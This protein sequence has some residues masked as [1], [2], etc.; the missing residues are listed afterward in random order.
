MFNFVILLIVFFFFVFLLALG[1]S[2]HNFPDESG[3]D[4]TIP[5]C[6]PTRWRAS[7]P[8]SGRSGS[9]CHPTSPGRMCS[10]GPSPGSI[11]SFR[12]SGTPFLPLFSSFFFGHL[13]WGRFCFYQSMP[14]L[15]GNFPGIV[16]VLA[17]FTVPFIGFYC[18]YPDVAAVWI[19]IATLFFSDIVFGRWDLPS[20]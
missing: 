13:S 5:R 18:S 10:P 12:T 15:N 7:P 16:T 6:G 17:S 8:G 20:A 11:Q 4:A 9:G 3:I 19:I 2:T 1:F 14:Y